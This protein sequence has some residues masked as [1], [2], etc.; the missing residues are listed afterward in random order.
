MSSTKA[1]YMVQA[2]ELQAAADLVLLELQ[3]RDIDRA[4]AQDD[5]MAARIVEAPDLLPAEGGLVKIGELFPLLAGDGEM[6]DA[7]H[8]IAPCWRWVRWRCRLPLSTPRR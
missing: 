2:G 7:T 3:H 5:A 1:P 6:P 8:V 4:V